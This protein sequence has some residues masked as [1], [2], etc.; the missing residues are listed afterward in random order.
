MMAPGMDWN[1][2]RVPPSRERLAGV[3]VSRLGAVIFLPGYR[4]WQRQNWRSKRLTLREY[5]LAA[6]YLFIGWAHRQHVPWKKVLDLDLVQGVLMRHTRTVTDDGREVWRREPCKLPPAWR[7]GTGFENLVDEPPPP[8]SHGF[9]VG[10]A[11][12]ITHGAFDRYP[13]KCV[14]IEGIHARVLYQLFGSEREITIPAAMAIKAQ[15]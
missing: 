6:G 9:E 2:L 11:V 15:A 12:L 3:A 14:A 8:P 1:V 5:P 13:A 10:D 4:Q 7:M